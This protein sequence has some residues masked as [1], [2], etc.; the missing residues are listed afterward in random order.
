MREGRIS[1]R[2]GVQGKEGAGREA[3]RC[4][5]VFLAMQEIMTRTPRQAWDCEPG[6]GV[7]PS[8]WGA[9]GEEG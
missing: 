3:L 8:A 6:K 4:F 5:A 2:E 9:G 1:K 7:Y